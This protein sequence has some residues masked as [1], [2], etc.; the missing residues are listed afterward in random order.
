MNALSQSNRF[1]CTVR[2]PGRRSFAKSS[3]P[4]S[5]AIF[6]ENTSRA[7]APTAKAIS[8]GT[9]K[10]TSEDK[11]IA[12]PARG[13]QG[14]PRSP[15]P[16][17]PHLCSVFKAPKTLAAKTPNRLTKQMLTADIFSAFIG[18]VSSPQSLG[19]KCQGM[20]PRPRK[21][22]LAPAQQVKIRHMKILLEAIN[23]TPYLK[24]VSALQKREEFSTIPRAGQKVAAGKRRR[25]AVT[26]RPDPSEAEEKGE[27]L[28]MLSARGTSRRMI[29]SSCSTR[30][31]AGWL[32]SPRMQ[33]DE[34]LQAVSPIHA[35][36]RNRAY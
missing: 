9:Q 31:E 22:Q 28:L 18:P 5:H 26:P 25:L 20:S 35:P 19:H 30:K 15:V 4:A 12:V 16:L 32:R 33:L 34:D 29:F 1:Y 10:R 21:P 36:K 23:R 14:I 27:S 8:V 24:A 7:T 11:G 2:A 13:V 17:P 6:L 3:V